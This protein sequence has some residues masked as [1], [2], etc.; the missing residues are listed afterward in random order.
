MSA[1]LITETCQIVWWKGYVKGRFVAL[2]ESDLRPAEVVGESRPIRWRGSGEPEP[3][4]SAV[5]ALDALTES[6]VDAGWTLG[7]PRADAWFGLVL[8]R[9]ATQPVVPAVAEDSR[10]PVA[11]REV[12][13]SPAEAPAVERL[14]LELVRALDE[15]EHER[16]LR[17]E[18]EQQAGHWA[19]QQAAQQSARVAAPSA[20]SSPF[21]PHSSRGHRP[22]L[23]VVE[24]ATVAAASVIALL[25]FDSAYAAAVAALT[26]GAVA[27][28]V[29]S[30]LAV[31]ARRE[32]SPPH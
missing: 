27:L 26:A 1:T 10:P 12:P 23:T 21:E 9:P 28:G 3:T 2:L 20:P 19:E 22:I 7:E 32:L 15:I 24:V 18:A 4:E 13:G 16:R 5:E 30:L 17:E 29:D 25:L 8:S 11:K 31:R 6:L 14:H